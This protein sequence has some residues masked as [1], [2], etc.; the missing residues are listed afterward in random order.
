MNSA[1]RPLTNTLLASLL[2]ALLIGV[3]VFVT[4]VAYRLMATAD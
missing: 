4:G 2:A 1:R 3:K